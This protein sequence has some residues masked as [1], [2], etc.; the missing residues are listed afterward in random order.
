MSQLGVEHSTTGIY[1][2]VDTTKVPVYKT[3]P[4]ESHVEYTN[5]L[6]YIGYFWLIT[7]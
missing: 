2:R 3:T 4:P 5:V 1:P 7:M 6:K